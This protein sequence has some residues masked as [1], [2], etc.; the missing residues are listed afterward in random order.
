[1]REKG[2]KGADHKTK[3]KPIERGKRVDQRKTANICVRRCRGTT[4]GANLSLD[5]PGISS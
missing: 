5:T 4:N 1:V 3:K 2:E